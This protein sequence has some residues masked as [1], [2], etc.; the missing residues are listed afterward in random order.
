MCPESIKITDNAIIPLKERVVDASY[1]PIAWLGRKIRH[2]KKGTPAEAAAS[3]AAV[4]PAAVQPRPEVHGIPAPGGAVSTAPGP[5][6][7]EVGVAAAAPDPAPETATA[8]EAA[9]DPS[10]G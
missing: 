5:A 3:A 10:A 9:E 6:D 7:D 8:P 2:R 4:G 1:D